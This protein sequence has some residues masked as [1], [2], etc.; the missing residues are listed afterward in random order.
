MIMFYI[1]ELNLSGEKELNED[2]KFFNEKEFIVF[3]NSSNNLKYLKKIM[4]SK[5][6]SIYLMKIMN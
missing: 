1:I 6:S 5:S 4:E 2:L 3:V